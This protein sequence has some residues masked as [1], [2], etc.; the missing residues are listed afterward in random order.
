MDAFMNSMHMR[1][2]PLIEARWFE[3][4]MSSLIFANPIAIAPQVFVA[5]T[6][7]SVEAIAV[8][9]W[10]IFSAIQAAFVFNGIKTKNFSVFASMLISLIE[11]IAIIV[12]VYVRG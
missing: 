8:P 1:F 9:M 12:T 5:F 6:A 7:P 10:Y 11:S 2:A 4:V 3:V